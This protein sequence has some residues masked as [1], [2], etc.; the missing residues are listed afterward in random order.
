MT[1]T[2]SS[3]REL[4]IHA[5]RFFLIQVLGDEDLLSVDYMLES[6]RDAGGKKSK[7]NSSLHEVY[8][9]S[10]QGYTTKSAKQ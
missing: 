1:E 4:N 3:L 7:S 6:I 8:N 9:T 10:G 5:H 2:H